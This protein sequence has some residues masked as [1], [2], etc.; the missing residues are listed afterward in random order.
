MW[1]IPLCIHDLLFIAGID[2]KKRDAIFFIFICAQVYFDGKRIILFHSFPISFMLFF[3]L[4]NQLLSCLFVHQSSQAQRD[5]F[6]WL[7]F[8]DRPQ[9]Y[10]FWPNSLFCYNSILKCQLSIKISHKII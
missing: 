6:S 3:F 1:T 7:V 8:Q 10:R 5:F 9:H 4:I 2:A